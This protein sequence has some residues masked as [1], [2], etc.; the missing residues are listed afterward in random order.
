MFTKSM[1]RMLKIHETV[2]IHK[3]NILIGFKMYRV[4]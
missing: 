1:C 3:D 4:F 2:I